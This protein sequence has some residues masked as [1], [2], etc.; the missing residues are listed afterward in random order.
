MLVVLVQLCISLRVKC[1]WILRQYCV[2]LHPGMIHAE[3][4]PLAHT[5]VSQQ[6]GRIVSFLRLAMTQNPGTFTSKLMQR[7]TSITCLI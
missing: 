6:C 5:A 4:V 3:H 1:T 7:C 2:S